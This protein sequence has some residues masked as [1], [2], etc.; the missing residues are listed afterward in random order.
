MAAVAQLGVLGLRLS[1][2]GGGHHIASN[3]YVMQVNRGSDLVALLAR[4]HQSEVYYALLLLSHF[5]FKKRSKYFRFY[6]IL[7]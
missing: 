1:G 5:L 7:S 6:G 4:C 3:H 2:L